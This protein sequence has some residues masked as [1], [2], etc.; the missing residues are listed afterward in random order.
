VLWQWQRARDLAADYKQERDTARVQRERADRNLVRVR[1]QMDQ[2]SQLGHDLAQAPGTYETGKAVLEKVLTCYDKLLPEEGGDPQLRREAVQVYGQVANIRHSLGQWAEAVEAYQ[3]QAALLAG[4]LAE[5]PASTDFRR[6][7]ARSHRS[8]GNVLRDMGRV[9]EARAAYHQ[10]A[11]LHE[12][13]QRESPEDAG[14]RMEL[15]NT[16]INK[17][18]VLSPRDETEEL[19]RLF[20]RVMDLNRA[21]VAADPGNP[22]YRA[23]LALGLEEQ[24][25]F[26]LALGM[27][28]RAE[29]VI[30]EALAIRQDL[31]AGGHLKGVI[32]RY[33][34]RNHAALGRALAAA[35]QVDQAKQSYE[36]AVKL[37][38]ALAKEFPGYPYHRA[39]LAEARAQLAE[40]LKGRDQKPE[41]PEERR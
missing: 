16:L 27:T 25:D 5:E 24:G 3:T 14:C 20:E 21:A 23:N 18:T 35:G 28:A 39:D 29:L 38:E 36:E 6:R 2:L 40:L 8:R 10:A 1:E 4:L 31:V 13:L 34:A 22:R 9:R 12:E 41:D 37:F 17:A 26:F 33:L 32:E 30:R 19:G 11:T 7:L 15:A